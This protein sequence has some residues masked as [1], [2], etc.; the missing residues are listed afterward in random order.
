MDKI[1]QRLANL[2]SI[3]SIVTLVL[4]CVFSYLAVTGKNDPELTAI[5]TTVVGFF[6]GTQAAKKE[7]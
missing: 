4:T 2:L 1:T 5:Y 7:S 6:F 3:K